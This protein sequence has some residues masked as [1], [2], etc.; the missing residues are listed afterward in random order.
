[1]VYLSSIAEIKRGDRITKAMLVNGGDYSVISGGIEPMGRYTQ[2]NR[3]ANTITIASYGAAGYVGF[4]KEAFWANDV[5]L[6]VIP[7]DESII[8]NKYLYYALKAQQQ[9]LYDNT[10]HAI[11][12]H[13][14]TSILEGLI[15]PVPPECVQKD[16]VNKLDYFTEYIEDLSSGLPAEINLRLKQYEYYRD[17]LLTFTEAS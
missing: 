12:D 2:A 3:K 9:Y 11:P 15:I 10:T 13:I 16:I 1:M 8:R 4:I 5:C 6:S 7:K 14:P 17:K